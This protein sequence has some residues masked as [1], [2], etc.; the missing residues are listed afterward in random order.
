L[1][2]IDDHENT[3]LHLACR[4]GA[5]YRRTSLSAVFLSVNL[6][7]YQFKISL[8]GQ[9]SRQNVSFMCKFSI[10]S[11][12]KWDAYN[13]AFLYHILLFMAIIQKS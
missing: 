10:F 4:Q 2:A 3:A 9:N 13:E 1:E 8:K 5:N 7:V 11:P 6:L 12:K